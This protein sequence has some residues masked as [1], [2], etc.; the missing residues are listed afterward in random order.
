MHG[1]PDVVEEL[2]LDDGL[3]AS[4][5]IA[6]GPAHDIGF[7]QRRVEDALG[8]EL[9]LQAGGE[10]EDAAFAL[11]LSQRLF[12]AGVGHVFAID[13]DARIAAHLVV[14]AG[15]DQVGHGAGFAALFAAGF[16]AACGCPAPAACLGG[17]CRAG[18]VQIFGINVR[19]DA[20]HRRQRRLKRP[21]GG[22]GRLAVQRLLECVDLVL[23]QNSLAQQAHLHLGQRIA[24]GIGFAL[25][26]GAV[27]LVVV[28]S[29]WE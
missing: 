29:E 3:H 1:R 18:R 8:A 10:L 13:H 27:E 15:V 23:G 25:S 6:D 26:S 28:G 21:L 11:D 4:H 9:G 17:E 12:A 16:A 22:L 7:G 14:Q 5:G 19:R 24:Q 2:N 20:R